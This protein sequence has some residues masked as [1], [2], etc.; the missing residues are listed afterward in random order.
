MKIDLRG[1][2]LLKHFE[3]YRLEAYQ[4]T[5][6]VWTVGVGHTGPEVVAGLRIS[7][8]QAEAL[9]R[10]DV[11]TAEAAVNRGITV[12]MNQAQ[13]DA[14]TSLT[15][16]IG[17][18]AFAASSVRRLFNSGDPCAAAFAFGMWRKDDNV[19]V[20]SLA[21]RRAAE[22]TLFFE[23]GFNLPTERTSP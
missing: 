18:R 5:G 1:I 14:F 9:L 6:G 4:D 7:E 11:A 23:D 21:R 22:I 8:A 3:G 2:S 16:N 13:F 19:D 12:P 10:S 17:A 20:L 15:Y